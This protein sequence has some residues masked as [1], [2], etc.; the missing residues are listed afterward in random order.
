MKTRFIPSAPVP[1]LS[2]N[3]FPA[4][5]PMELAPDAVAVAQEQAENTAQPEDLMVV[6]P[7]EPST[8]VEAPAEPLQAAQAS[9]SALDV[10]LEVVQPAEVAS[11]EEALTLNTGPQEEVIV[12]GPVY[13][14]AL[15]WISRNG[16]AYNKTVVLGGYPTLSS[17]WPCSLGTA[18]MYGAFLAGQNR[19]FEI[20][21]PEAQEPLLVGGTSAGQLYGVTQV[22]A[23]LTRLYEVQRSLFLMYQSQFPTRL[24]IGGEEDGSIAEIAILQL[25]NMLE[26]AHERA[27]VVDGSLNAMDLIAVAV[28]LGLRRVFG[29]LVPLDRLGALLQDTERMDWLQGHAD[30]LLGLPPRTRV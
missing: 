5:A 7:V 18:M 26:G 6:E 21:L 11:L 20:L 17:S 25:S 23:E 2:P 27:K 30:E 10:P 24:V 12:Q 4:V 28:A 14:D 8:V 1:P 13:A 16:L 9:S 22:A 29:G 15:E 3:A 19:P